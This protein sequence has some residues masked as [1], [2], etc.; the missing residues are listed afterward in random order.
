MSRLL[1]PFQGG[2]VGSMTGALVD[3]GAVP[4]EAVTLKR[5]DNAICGVRLLPWRVDVLDTQQPAAAEVACLQV[6]GSRGEQGAE[7]QWPGGRGR[8]APDV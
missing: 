7:M 8:K 4:L 5:L 3:D 6:A 2:R 1:Q